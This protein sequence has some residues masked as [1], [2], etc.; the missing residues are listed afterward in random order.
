LLADLSPAEALVVVED[1][2]SKITD[3]KNVNA[4]F[5][6][7]SRVSA[8]VLIPQMLLKLLSFILHHSNE[9]FH[10]IVANCLLEVVFFQFYSQISLPLF[11]LISFCLMTAG[12]GCKLLA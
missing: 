8:R 9:L 2:A 12:Y 3:L 10:K 6:V 1:A 5:S 7:R 11:A 4:Y